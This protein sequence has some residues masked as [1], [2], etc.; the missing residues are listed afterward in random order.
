[1]FK[2]L[3]IKVGVILTFLVKLILGLTC[4]G[5]CIGL[6]IGAIVEF[7]LTVICIL[8]FLILLK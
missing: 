8:L 4:I 2:K 1:M 5:L 6:F 3:T 7:P